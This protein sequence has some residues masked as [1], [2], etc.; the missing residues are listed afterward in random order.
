MKK[1]IFFLQNW[2]KL[3][4]ILI[5]AIAGVILKSELFSINF[6]YAIWVPTEKF[7]YFVR[8]EY[9]REILISQAADDNSFL[10]LWNERVVILLSY[11]ELLRWSERVLIIRSPRASP[12]FKWE[13]A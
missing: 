7:R 10:M 8:Q 3:S 2:I 1:S 11:A 4:F 6:L 5:S 13:Y 12:A 9:K